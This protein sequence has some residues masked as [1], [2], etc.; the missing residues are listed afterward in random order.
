MNCLVRSPANLSNYIK[1]SKQVIGSVSGEVAAP[2]K[3]PEESVKVPSQPL[4]LTSRSLAA[5]AQGGQLFAQAAGF[6][7]LGQVR[8][9]HTDIQVPNFDYYRKDELKDPTSSSRDSEDA[10]K[11][12]SY[13]ALTV[14][15]VGG[16]YAA[17]NVVTQ[18]IS[19]MAASADVLA[20]AK[21]EVSL[22]EIEEGKSMTFKWRGKPLFVRHRTQEE[23]KKESA[24]DITQLRDPQA[25]IDRVQ[26]PEWLVLIGVCTHLGCVP[27]PNVGDYKGYFCPCHGSHYDASGRIRKGPAP[28][29][30][31]VPPYEF[32]T[33]STLMVG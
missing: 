31:E 17:K 2:F 24:V 22:S 11:L 30:L 28:L 4:K 27:I 1:V 33:D 20:L 5:S 3:V 12:Q 8:L 21:V 7:V 13:V 15:G 25:D 16:A 9:A 32:T 26:K 6:G 19:S 14:A 29:N 10:R 23:I 18:F